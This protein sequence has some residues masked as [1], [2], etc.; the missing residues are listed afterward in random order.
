VNWILLWNSLLVGASAAAVAVFLGACVALTASGCAARWRRLLLAASA[1]AL[2]LPPFLAT[3]TW[4]HLLGNNGVWKAWFPFEIHSRTG[5]IWV[6]GLLEWPLPAL[7]FLSAW[8]DIQNAHLESE[9]TLAGTGLMRWLLIPMARPALL[10]AYSLA[11]VLGL[12]NFAVPA[13]LQT[14]VLGAEVWVLFNTTYNYTAAVI[15]GIPLVLAPLILLAFIRSRVIAWNRLDSGVNPALLRSRLGAAWVLPAAFMTVSVVGLSVAVPLVQLAVSR[16]TWSELAPAIAAGGPALA[17]SI[18]YAA[19]S[20]TIV[21]AAGWRLRRSA[22]GWIAWIPFLAPGI[23]L[24]LLLIF[25]LNRPYLSALYQ[26]SAVVLLAFSIRYLAVGWRGARHAAASLDSELVEAGRLAGARNWRHWVR[27]H[28]NQA[29]PALVS[30]WYVIYL[31]GLWDV[32]TLILIIPPGAE[33]LSLRVFNLLHYGHNAQVD[34]LCLVLVAVAVAPLM[35]AWI[36]RRAW[37]LTRVAGVVSILFLAGGCAPAPEGVTPVESRV[38]SGVRVIGGMGTGL[39]EF[40]KP[41]SIAVDSRD[42]MYAVD[43]TGRVQK[44][45]SDGRVL[46]C[47]QLELTEKGRPKGM[48]MD[49]AGRVIVIEPHYSRVNHFS[50]TGKLEFQWGTF[51]TNQGQ[52]TFPR[53]AAINSR[54]EICLSEYGQSERVQRFSQ[55]GSQYLGGFGRAGQ[56]TG[57]FNRPEGLCVDAADRILVADSCNHRIQVFAPDGRFLRSFGSPGRHLGELSYPYDIRLDAAGRRYVCEFGNSRIQVF[58]AEDRPVEIIGGPGA[59]PGRFNNPWSLAF[60]SQGNL[61][62]ADARNNRVQKLLRKQETAAVPR[63]RPTEALR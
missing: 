41:R 17:N 59:A 10:L 54:G 4:L 2:A 9:P 25:A 13:L 39:G 20:A 21:L 32:E 47:W 40:N 43:M 36:A 55:D 22:V 57:E 14:P 62:V 12:N 37:A 45:S 30:A 53:A 11:L 33:T 24:G 31:L 44:F 27:L 61:Y 18:L 16:R 51:G 1:V 50:V 58:D 23:F 48:C 7:L 6:L 35:G 60:D 8:S 19:G 5:A 56:G 38:F 34:A 49:A 63:S 3:N 29:G 42:N 52:I 28:G 46:G 15:Q 26:S